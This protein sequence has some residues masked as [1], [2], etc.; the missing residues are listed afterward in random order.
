MGATKATARITS[1]GQVT[2]PKAVRD[3]LGLR[4]GD[5]LT[6]V[7]DATGVRVEKV[8]DGSPF[9][10]WYGHLSHLEGTSE[11]I[12]AEIRGPDPGEE[13]SEETHGR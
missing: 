5:N 7:E 8:L 11:E 10:K 9:R 3:S 4:Q 12:F 6:F 1:K 2:I 13:V